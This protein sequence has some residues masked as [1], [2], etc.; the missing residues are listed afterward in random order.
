VLEGP[1]EGAGG[2]HLVMGD[3]LLGP[4]GEVPRHIHSGEE[5][6]FVLAGSATIIRDGMPDLTIGA[7]QGVRIAPGL[8]H[9]GLAGPEGVRAVAS[10][11]VVDGQ[12]LRSPVPE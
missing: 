10:W 3:L 4:N 7:G 12:P 1:I 9:S 8:P 6:L 5:F 11:V 2:H